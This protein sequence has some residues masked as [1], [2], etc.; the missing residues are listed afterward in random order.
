VVPESM[1]GKTNNCKGAG[2]ECC[3][4]WWPVIAIFPYF[5]ARDRNQ[6]NSEATIQK[7]QQKTQLQK[8]LGGEVQVPAY[9]ISSLTGIDHSSEDDTEGGIQ[10]VV[11]GGSLWFINI[12]IQC[13]WSHLYMPVADV[14]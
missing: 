11:A 4:C 8:C 14:P 3:G 5:L 1:V 2:G 9:T 6:V 7:T 12:Y 13:F 10:F